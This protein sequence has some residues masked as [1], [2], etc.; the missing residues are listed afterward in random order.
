M[1]ADQR[2]LVIGLYINSALYLTGVYWA[3]L[4]YHNNF[5][6]KMALAA[7]GLSYVGYLAQVTQIPR[8]LCGIVVGI[9]AIVGAAAGLSLVFP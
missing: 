2:L 6:W 5:A 3:G 7:A 1:T 8:A 4:I 9:S